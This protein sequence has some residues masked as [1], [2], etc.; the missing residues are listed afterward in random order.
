MS[1]CQT[2]SGVDNFN[3]ATLVRPSFSRPLDDLVGPLPWQRPPVAMAALWA[4]SHSSVPLARSLGSL[5]SASTLLRL[6]TFV[7]RCE[8]RATNL[9]HASSTTTD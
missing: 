6:V 7:C 3:A 9:S 5:A 4:A 1:P 8:N 2:K